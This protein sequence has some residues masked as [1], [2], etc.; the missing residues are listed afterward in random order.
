MIG[1]RRSVL[2]ARQLTEEVPLNVDALVPQD[3]LCGGKMKIE[4]RHRELQEKLM[5]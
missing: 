5:L 1:P 2:L 4:T 3:R